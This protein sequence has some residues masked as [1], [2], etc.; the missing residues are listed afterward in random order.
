MSETDYSD[1]TATFGDRLTAARQ[2]AGLKRKEVAR[3]LGVK[4]STLR[5]W[6]EDLNEPRANRLT[7][8]AGMTG[9]SLV[10][11]MTGQGAGP[12]GGEAVEAGEDAGSGG[13]TR[14][15][16]A[17]LA[18]DFAQARAELTAVNRRLSGIERR[19]SRLI[20]D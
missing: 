20:R 8:L 7:I 2:G 1:A 6:E 14:A 9:V 17:E 3:Q 19:L 4:T 10:W 13:A 18:R 16:F 15:A 12:L 5:N 11:L